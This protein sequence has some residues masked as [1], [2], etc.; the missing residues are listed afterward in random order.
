MPGTSRLQVLAASHLIIGVGT[1]V[2]APIHLSNPF[3]LGHILTVPFVAS[4]LCQA[5]LIAMWGAFSQTTAWKRL[6]G[7][8]VAAVCLEAVVAP[9]FRREFLGTS[10]ITITVTTASLLV[11]RWLGVRFTRQAEFGQV[12]RPEPEGLRFSIRDLMI[13]TAT[14]A[15]LCAG[16][17]AL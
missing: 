13:L 7:L 4:A 3:G 9:D 12:A 17:K 14:V 8:G 6:A 10:T 16:A 5:F 11:V 1:A 2:L 15:F